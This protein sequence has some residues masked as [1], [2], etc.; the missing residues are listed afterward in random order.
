[1]IDMCQ[2]GTTYLMVITMKELYRIVYTQQCPLRQRFDNNLRGF[3]N[4]PLLYKVTEGTDKQTDAQP[5]RGQ[6]VLDH[7]S[8]FV[9]PSCGHAS[10]L[11]SAY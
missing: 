7:R 3:T 1:M 11:L 2:A 5:S 8:F 9:E 10:L 4:L 6:L